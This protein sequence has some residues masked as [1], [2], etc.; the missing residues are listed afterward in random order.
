MLFNWIK[1]KWRG[2]LLGGNWLRNL[3]DRFTIRLGAARSPR[4]NEIRKE[5]LKTHLKCEACGRIRGI[6]P[7]H[8][9]PFHLFPQYEL[10]EKNLIALCEG[11]IVNCH[12]LFGHCYLSWKSYNENV[13]ESIESIK[14]IRKNAKG[15]GKIVP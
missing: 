8:V 10:L 4:W 9:L 3:F 2:N 1:D 13:W 7:H 12:F 6:V 11:P 14:E 5:F 15:I